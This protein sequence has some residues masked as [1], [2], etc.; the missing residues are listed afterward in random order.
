MLLMSLI[1][2][3]IYI[4]PDDA[5]YAL[6]PELQSLGEQVLQLIQLLP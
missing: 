1:L 3:Q 2:N 5:E 4:E 6:F